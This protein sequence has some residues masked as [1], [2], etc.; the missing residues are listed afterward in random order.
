MYTVNDQLRCNA[1]FY[2]V[3]STAMQ[4]EPQAQL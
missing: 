3:S 4:F 2:S 1:E